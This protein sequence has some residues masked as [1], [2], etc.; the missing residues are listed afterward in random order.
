MQ[1]FDPRRSAAL[2]H[3]GTFNNN[4]IS[5]AAGAAGLTQIYTE[6]AAESLTRRGEVLRRGLNELCAERGAALQFTGIGSLMNAHATTRP[7]VGPVDV[8]ERQQGLKSLLFFHLLERGFYIARRGLISLSLPLGDSEIEG[9]V[10]AVW[11]CLIR[12]DKVW[13][14]SE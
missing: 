13:R 10:N 3:A 14:S 8:N 5:M 11:E 2:Q 1:L 6:A 7:V 12:Y 9:L 4:G